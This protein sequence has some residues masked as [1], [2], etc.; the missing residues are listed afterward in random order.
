MEIFL[1][2]VEKKLGEALGGRK[3]RKEKKKGKR[4]RNWKREDNLL[5]EKM[6]ISETQIPG[7]Q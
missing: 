2:E 7:I 1:D 5:E 3:G 6:K 4:K